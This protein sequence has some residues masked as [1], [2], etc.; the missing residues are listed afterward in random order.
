M[1]KIPWNEIKSKKYVVIHDKVYNLSDFVDIHP[2]GS[3]IIEKYYG[4]DATE[5]FENVCHSDR[6]I[7]MMEE[8]CV[9]DLDKKSLY[10]EDSNYKNYLFLGGFLFGIAAICAYLY[11]HK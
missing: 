5:D 4:K 6:A 9:G 2:G 8:Y 1:R 11:F 3:F 10:I 7:R